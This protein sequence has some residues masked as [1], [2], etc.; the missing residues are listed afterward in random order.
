MNDCVALSDDAIEAVM[1]FCPNISIL[2]FDGCPRLT[3][4]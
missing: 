1:Q 4:M 2:L 3:G